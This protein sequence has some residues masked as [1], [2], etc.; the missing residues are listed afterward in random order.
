MNHYTYPTAV[1]DLIVDGELKDTV[2]APSRGDAN[3]MFGERKPEYNTLAYQGRVKVPVR[4]HEHAPAAGNI[5]VCVFCQTRL[6]T[7]KE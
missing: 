4:E 2:E 5:G 6:T 7:D 3:R 1:F